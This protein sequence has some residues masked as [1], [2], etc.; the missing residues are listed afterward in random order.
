MLFIDRAGALTNIRRT[1]VGGMLVDA[2]LAKVGVMEYA[3]GQ[4]VVRRRNPPEALAAACADVATAPVTNRHPNR[5]V[6]THNYK[7]LSKGHVV[8]QPTF[9]DGHICATLAINDAQLIRDIEMGVCREVSMGYS[10]HHDG[11]PGV[12]EDGQAYDESRVKIEWNHIAIVPEGRAGKSVRLMLDSADI[13]QEDITMKINGIEVA[14]D[15]AQAAFDSYDAGL[16]AKI[17]ELTA[18]LDAAKAEKAQ[19]DAKLAVATSPETLKAAVEAEL[20]RV[21]AQKAAD[22]KRSK[23]AAA[24]PSISLDGKSEDFVDALFVALAARPVVSP[25][26]PEGLT[27]LTRPNVVN[28]AKQAPKAKPESAED[29]YRRMRAEERARSLDNSGKFATP[30]A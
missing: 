18:Q 29:A 17:A 15:S 25:S 6:D 5:F 19:L 11:V 14:M 2:K 28:D 3:S 24:Y 27:L 13:P 1:A 26:D 8:G 9:V 16:Q 30:G 7:E 12:T 21:E 10:A 4:K 20:A 23:V 22:E